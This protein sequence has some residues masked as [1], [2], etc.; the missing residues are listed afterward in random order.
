M[1]R[2]FVDKNATNWDLYIG[3]LMAAYRS[4]PHPAK[5]YSLN[6]LMLEERL[7]CLV[8]S[9]FPCLVPILILIQIIVA[10]IKDKS[11]EIYHTVRKNFNMIRVFLKLSFPEEPLYIN[12]IMSSKSLRRGGLAHML[13]LMF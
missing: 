7:S 12:L 13:S 9:Y 5:G 11:E 3:I 10:S 1:I 4:T 6:M 8:S 2:S